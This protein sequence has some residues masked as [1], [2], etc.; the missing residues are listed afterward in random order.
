MKGGVFA[1]I[2]MKG[3]IYLNSVHKFVKEKDVGLFPLESR[4]FFCVWWNKRAFDV[5]D[6]LFSEGVGHDLMHVYTYNNWQL[7]HLFTE[8]LL[9]GMTFLCQI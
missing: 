4:T 9:L 3:K 7:M 8:N 1:Q 5:C 6:G 2:C